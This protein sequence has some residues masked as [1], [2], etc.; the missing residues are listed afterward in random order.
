MSYGCGNYMCRGDPGFFGNLF[1]AITGVVGGGLKGLI[2]GG[3]IGGIVGAVGGAVG[4]TAHNI[5]SATL[6]AGGSQSALTPAL[7]AAHK[8]AVARGPRAALPGGAGSR[9]LAGGGGGTR[10]RINWANHRALG[11][12]E[13]RIHSAV[14]HMSKYIRW[15]HPKKEGHAA[16]SFRAHKTSAYPKVKHP[17]VGRGHGGRGMAIA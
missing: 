10:R 17:G 9:A 13:R 14:K 7:I 5:G 1:H 8:A 12:A 16:P 11:R 3:P 6:E 4:A 15:V 2:T